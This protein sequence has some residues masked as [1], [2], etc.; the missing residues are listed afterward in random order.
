MY[1]ILSYKPFPTYEISLVIFFITKFICDIGEP[2]S[3]TI[4][5]DI[6]RKW[7]VKRNMTCKISKME[8][9]ETSEN[10]EKPKQMKY[11]QQQSR[12]KK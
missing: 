11:E 2:D 1:Y 4:F 3:C 8:G 9:D 7:I 10:D 6:C 12:W 5:S